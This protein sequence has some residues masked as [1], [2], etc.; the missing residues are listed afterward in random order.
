MGN[1]SIDDQTFRDLNIFTEQQGSTSIFNLFKS[2][3]TIG[4]R[5][6]LREIMLKPSNDI[7]EISGRKNAIKYFYDH[8]I[9]LGFSNEELDLVE[10]YLKLN[11]VKFRGNLIDSMAEYLSR[12]S[13]NDYYII[14]TGLRY[15]IKLVKY[16][17]V[18]IQEHSSTEVPDYLSRIFRQIEELVGDSALKWAI[19]LNENNLKF[20]MVSKLDRALRVKEK[21]RIE[22]LLQ[23]IYELDVFENI[24]VVARKRGFSFPSYS[25][26]DEFTVSLTGLF[27]PGIS[28][29]IKNDVHFDSDQ[30]MVFLTGSNMA[31]KSSLLKA[32]G[33]VIYLAH[34]G[35]PVPADAMETTIFNG[36]ITTINLPDDIDHGLSHYYS[37]VRRVKA[38]SETLLGQDRMFVIFDELFRGTNVKDAFD[39]SKLIISELSHIKNT[40]FFISTH[41]VELAA[42]LEQYHNISFRCLETNFEAGKPVF[43]Y[44]LSP[45]VSK[46]RLGMYIVLN[47]GIV[48]VI[49]AACLKQAER[50][51]LKI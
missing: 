47:E 50:R 34:L 35:F 8:N 51:F 16:A 31:G 43:S 44:L 2:T 17:L 26:A 13:N 25:A 30:N 37:E 32:I 7:E 20:L 40:A 9:S 6:R 49:K 1:F 42:E 10:F 12:K 21:K 11:K 41:I 23:L 39:A 36:L 29:P 28:K 15:L 45:G 46:E 38:V 4:G 19:L 27:H 24:A 3:N 22:A 33:L 48:D 14:K 5:D 18:F